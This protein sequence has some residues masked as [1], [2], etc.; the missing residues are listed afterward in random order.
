[1]ELSATELSQKIR[2]K[3]LQIPDVVDFYLQRIEK[4]NP[5]LNAVVEENFSAAREKAKEQQAHLD[6]LSAEER[7]KLP[8]FFGV[9]YT[10]KEMIAVKGKRSTFGSLHRKTNVMNENATVVERME[11]AGAILLGM[12]NVPEAAFWFEC[13][14]VIYGKSNN[15]YDTSRTPG[16][17]SGGEAA[18][19]GAGAS[20]MGIGSDIGGSI[21]MPAAFCGVFGHKPSDLLIPITG[22]FP[23]YREY[24]AEYVGNKRPFAVI[25]PMSKRAQ[26]LYPMMKLLVGPD[27]IDQEIKKD[28]NLQPLVKNPE[29]IKVFYLPSPVIH[30]TSSLH[31]LLENSVTFA[32][33][34]LKEMGSEIESVD[35]K[36]FIQAFE[37][38][39]ARAQT[40]Q[41]QNFTSFLSGKTQLNFLKEF[42]SLLIGRRNYTFPAL[43]TAMLDHYG[44][45]RAKATDRLVDL[46]KL[47]KQVS[48]LLGKNGVLI[49]PVH[50]RLAPKHHTTYTRPFDFSYTAIINALGM[51]ATSVPMGLSPEGLPLSVQVVADENCD[52]LCL[53]VA[54]WLEQ[55][56]GGWQEPKGARS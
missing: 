49:M 29:D 3:E 16:G 54:E 27:D 34:Y 39:L 7:K 37:L 50:P 52:H 18:V 53:S 48:S 15:P 35:R 22:Q 30:G 36:I 40:I 23:L 46:T 10:C 28:F 1:M 55:G 43:L 21:R 45:D 17:S 20:P 14:N 19:L 41:G 13:D 4:E 47:K 25:G 24:A 31:P 42:S 8:V 5:R 33:R 12:T 44:D 2:N 32:A 9:P 26:D 11:E 56:F 51:P 6:S 38:W